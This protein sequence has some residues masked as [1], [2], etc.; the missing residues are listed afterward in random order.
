MKTS[1]KILIIKPSSL[2]DVIHSLP[3]LN[4]LRTCFP[5]DEIHWVIA[6]GLED[7]VECHPM[8]D[9]VIVINKDTWKKISMTGETLH[10]AAQLFRTLRQEAYDMVIDLQGLL[11]SGLLAA[12]TGASERVGFS[13]AREGSRFFYTTKISGGKE[14]HAVDRYLKIAAALGCDPGSVLFPFPLYKERFDEIEALKASLGKYAVIVPG[15]RWQTKVWPA[16]NFGNVAARLPVS[17][18]VIGGSSDVPLAEGVVKSS[19]GRAFSLAGKTS[20]RGL[21]EV[22][23]D[24]SVVLTNDSGPMHIAA[25][26]GVPVVAVFGPTSAVR[27]GPYGGVN[28]VIQSELPC[29]PCF[30][31][32]CRDVRC[33]A[34]VSADAVFERMRNLPFFQGLAARHGSTPYKEA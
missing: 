26:L 9:R 31:R 34:G 24:A 1:K 18:I 15:A 29:A 14:I 17:S 4:A 8:I 28:I 16:G 10:E 22:M 21:M 20:L 6:R 7:L 3:F 19:R 30:K 23:R 12:A 11:R 5:R 32:R 27:T 2:G 33:M 25:A 13:E